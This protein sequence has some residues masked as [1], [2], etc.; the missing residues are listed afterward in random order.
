MRTVTLQKVFNRIIRMLGH[1]PKD[2]ITDDIRDA[3]TDHINDR[4]QTIAQVWNWPEWDITEERAFRQV[5]NANHQYRKASLLDG[6][7][8]EVFYIPNTTYYK[9]NPASLIDP[10][11]GTPPTSLS[12]GNPFWIPL[13]NPIDTYVG[14]DQV[15]K[16]SI[17][18]VRGV[19]SSNPIS[20]P[21]GCNCSSN[22]KY[23]PSEKGIQIKGTVG[24]TVF[25]LYSMPMPEFTMIPFVLGK[26][27]TRGSLVLDPTIG[28]CFQATV[29]TTSLPSDNTQWNRVP[30][31]KVWENYTVW[32]AFKDSLMEYDQD[33]MTDLQ[34]RMVLAQNAEQTC[35]DEIQQQV[36]VLAAQ[37]QVLH[38]KPFPRNG[39][40]TSCWRDSQ[41]WSGGTVDT[42]TDACED[43]LGFVYPTPVSTPMV[44]WRFYNELV[45][46]DGIVPS[47]VQVPTVLLMPGSIAE[48]VIGPA[49]AR[50]RNTWQ[51]LAGGGDTSDPGQK[52]PLDYDSIQ[53]PVHWEKTSG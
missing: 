6:K 5:W 1:N 26:T 35:N 34:N 42:L 4:V 21:L 36:D 32:G 10:P 12:P 13:D 7:P 45:S 20:A 8:D 25:L 30:F 46:V 53:N 29:D 2:D 33:G 22:I 51:L 52:R 43:D 15:C 39:Y 17:G 31:L 19:F 27:Y 37:G 40:Q 28:E 11:L 14:Y 48:F 23:M 3:I 16:R 50:Q 38:W 9:A 44:S 24:P 49:G 18:I 47:L 41:D